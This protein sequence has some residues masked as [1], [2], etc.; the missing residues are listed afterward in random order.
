MFL[1]AISVGGD[2]PRDE[3]PNLFALFRAQQRL[4]YGFL[5]IDDPVRRVRFLRTD[6]E[7]H[8]PLVIGQ[9]TQ[10]HGVADSY[11]DGS[12][13][14]NDNPRIE[15]FSRRRRL[16][17]RRDGRDDNNRLRSVARLIGGKLRL[18]AL[19]L[20]EPVGNHASQNFC[21]SAG[22]VEPIRGPYAMEA[23]A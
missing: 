2:P 15:S 1:D 13:V 20:G 6:R 14:V 3:N 17:F 11:A 9:V 16:R 8:D 12:P 21:L 7:L 18:F 23:P 10:A 19:Q 22:T 4:G 5:I